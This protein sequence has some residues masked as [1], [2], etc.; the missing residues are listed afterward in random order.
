MVAKIDNVAA[1]A[2]GVL[3]S[4]PEKQGSGSN[5]GTARGLLVSR[6]RGNDS[7]APGIAAYKYGIEDFLWG[8]GAYG[9]SMEDSLW[10]MGMYR[11]SM[12]NSLWSMGM[13]RYSM[14]NSLW[15][16]GIYRYGM[17]GSLWG[18]EGSLYGI[19]RHSSRSAK[20]CDSSANLFV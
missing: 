13:Y 6:F 14:E 11:Y 4:S 17:E 1:P 9:Y 2:S 10:R 8:M 3:T 7:K 5:T 19:E 20:T 15:R 18:M 12:E 16:M